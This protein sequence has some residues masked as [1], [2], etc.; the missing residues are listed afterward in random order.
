MGPFGRALSREDRRAL[1]EA[2]VGRGDLR[3]PSPREL[4]AASDEVI[5]ILRATPFD[6]AAFAAALDALRREA[7]SLQDAGQAALVERVIAMS[8]AERAAF[9]DR[10]ERQVTRGPRP[11]PDGDRGG[12]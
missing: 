7:R 5:A 11:E 1:S 8:D 12:E 3:P 10:V 6:G 9:A 4:R 2:L